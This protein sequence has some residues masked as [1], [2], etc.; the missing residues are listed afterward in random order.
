MKELG[1]ASDFQTCQ[2]LYNLSWKESGGGKENTK[3]A[4]VGTRKG[5]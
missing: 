1:K 3:G 5:G 4:K 2:M